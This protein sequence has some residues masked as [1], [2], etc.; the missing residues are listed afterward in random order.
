MRTT[1]PYRDS[2]SQ[3][4][5]QR[6]LAEQAGPCV[7][8]FM[9]ILYHG[10]AEMQTEPMR[11]K[12]LLEQAQAQLLASGLPP[13]QAHLLLAP[14]HPYVTNE[15]QFWQ[16]QDAGLALFLTPDLFF[17][18]RLPITFDVQVSVGS[19]FY[20]RPLLP[21]LTGDGVFYLLA[22]SQNKVRLFKG[23]RNMQEEVCLPGSPHSLA[24][25]RQF[26]QVQPARQMHS[27]ESGG[28][29]GRHLTPVYT[30]QGTAGDEKLVKKDIEQF[31]RQVD[32]AV[33]QHLASQ[34][35]PLILAGVD[36]IR[37][38]YQEVTHYR[39]LANVHID[40]NPDRLSPTE[41]HER[42]WPLAAPL[43]QAPRQT[44]L[45][46]YRQLA[47]QE[48]TRAN[49]ALR[50]VLLDAYEKRID[51]LFVKAGIP[52]WGIVDATTLTMETHPQYQMGDEDL[53]NVAVVYTLRNR[54]TVYQLAPDQ[55]PDNAL[56][57]AILR[58]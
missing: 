21:L 57:A 2:I 27:V 29:G 44:A 19:H 18:Y 7:S 45:E 32:Q 48:D 42:A 51:T 26:N 22:L 11:L 36:S 50:L 9:P 47:G 35:A 39:H 1:Y 24:E 40:G 54:G 46:L 17:I 34:T 38:L 5:L 28:V 58:Y 16:Q 41:L 12:Q 52:Q 30:G 49:H 6:L 23:S 4:E 37:G 53:I 10:G 25:A 20:L 14:A 55:M 33:N 56:V 8:I 43:F 31:L 13:S 3:D 15:Q